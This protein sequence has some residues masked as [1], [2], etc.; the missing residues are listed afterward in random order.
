LH[1]A[2]TLRYFLASKGVCDLA[3]L[4]ERFSR[5]NRER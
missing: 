3:E 5:P 1:R 2:Y 4:P